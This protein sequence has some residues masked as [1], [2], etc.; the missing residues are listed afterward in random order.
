MFII[1]LS[2]QKPLTEVEK[3][4]DEHVKFLDKNYR[5][6]NFI[7]SGRQEPRVGGVILCKAPN[8]E[9][10][11]KIVATDPF[12]VHEIAQYN[13]IEFHPTKYVSDFEQFI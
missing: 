5:E 9:D 10:V 11:Q 6:N 1:I 13:V 2:Y 4:L 12:Y 3:Y 8:K 7:A